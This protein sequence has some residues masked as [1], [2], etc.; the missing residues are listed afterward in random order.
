MDQRKHLYHAVSH[1][2]V[3]LYYARFVI[4]VHI[5]FSLVYNRGFVVVVGTVHSFCSASSCRV[6]FVRIY[7]VRPSTKIRIGILITTGRDVR[8]AT[9]S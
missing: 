5:S 7:Y 2:F 8:C 9:S 1:V 3:I 4:I 6:H